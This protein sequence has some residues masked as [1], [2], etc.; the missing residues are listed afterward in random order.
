MDAVARGDG[1]VDIVPDDTTGPKDT[2]DTV[3]PEDGV[4]PADTPSPDA[5]T[6]DCSGKECGDDEC[7]GSC[8]TCSGGAVCQSGLCVCVPE[9]TKSCWDGDVWW[10]DSC[11]VKESKF[12]ECG[13][14]ACSDGACQPASCGDGSC[15]GDE[16]TCSCSGD[17]GA[18]AGCCQGTECKNGTATGECGTNGAACA[19]CSG[20]KTCQSQ[21]CDYKCGDGVCA[22]TP[23]GTETCCT[24]PSDCGP[25]CGNGACDCGETAETCLTDCGLTEGFVA[26]T[27]GTFWMG[28]PSGAGEACPPGYSGGGCNG[29]GTGTTDAEPGRVTDGRET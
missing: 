13:P 28:S 21:V 4:V 2:V 26:I 23:P 6:P 27:A 17:C 7:G 1:A 8:G 12:Q 24:C 3:T 22:S 14:T 5:C 10:Y 9:S 11:G 29:S 16:T 20:G 25:C 15:S 18:C 19:A